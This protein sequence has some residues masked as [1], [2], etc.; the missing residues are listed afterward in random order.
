MLCHLSN[1]QS[2][3]ILATVDVIGNNLTW[4]RKGH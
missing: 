4:Q 3:P 1:T 2:R